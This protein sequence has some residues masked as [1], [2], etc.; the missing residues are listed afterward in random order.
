LKKKKE[1]SVH[2]ESPCIY[3]YICHT[4][5]GAAQSL[6][7]HDRI[8]MYT[9]VYT[10]PINTENIFTWFIVSSHAHAKIICIYVVYIIIIFSCPCCSIQDGTARFPAF[11]CPVERKDAAKHKRTALYIILYN[12]ILYVVI[13]CSPS[14]QII[15]FQIFRYECN[16][17]AVLVLLHYNM[18]SIIY[19][20]A[21]TAVRMS[22]YYDL[23]YPVDITHKSTIVHSYIMHACMYIICV[24]VCIYACTTYVYRVQPWRTDFR[25]NLCCNRWL[26]FF[27]IYYLK[28]LEL[29][30]I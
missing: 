25:H 30:D 28:S 4:H 6:C 22:T 20:S 9:R 1:A 24:C 11:P 18:I 17:A 27:F 29:Y 19:Q 26:K 2:G 15:I 5:T 10:K 13:V 21:T 8:T 12:C 23:Q 14:E 16:L 3:I 7:K